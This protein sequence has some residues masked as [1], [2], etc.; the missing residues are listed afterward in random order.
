LGYLCDP[1]GKS[2]LV[3]AETQ[4]DEKGLIIMGKPVSS[5]SRSYLVRDG[6]PRIESGRRTAGCG[7]VVR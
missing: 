2:P 6:V 1:A 7:G 4:Y 3:L 5:S